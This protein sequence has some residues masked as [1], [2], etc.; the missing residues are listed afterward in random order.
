MIGTSHIKIGSAEGFSCIHLLGNFMDMSRASDASVIAG[1]EKAMTVRVAPC[2]HPTDQVFLA[3][4][5]HVQGCMTSDERS[6]RII[7]LLTHL[8]VSW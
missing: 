4:R 7:S 3:E 8:E 5:L 1:N 2:T 6:F